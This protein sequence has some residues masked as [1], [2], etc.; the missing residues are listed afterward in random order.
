M[1]KSLISMAVASVVALPMA[2]TA[3]DDDKDPWFEGTEVYGSLRPQIVIQDGATIN[4]GTSRWG[5]KGDHD[6]G[7]GLSAIYRMEYRVDSSGQ[8]DSQVG[9]LGYA[10]L[11]GG[12]GTVALGEQW[13]PYYN[14]VAAPSDLFPSAGIVF[15]P[16]P[17]RKG[18]ALTYALPGGAAISGA[19]ML[20]MGDNSSQ[21]GVTVTGVNGNTVTGPCSNC[22]TIED[23]DDVDEVDVGL[24][25]AAGPVTIGLGVRDVEGAD[26]EL[27]G[28]S[29]AGSFGDAGVILLVEDDGDNTPWAITGTYGGFALQYADNDADDDAITLGYTHKLGPKAKLQFAIEDQDSADDTKGVARVRVD[30]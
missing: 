19:I 24:S 26:D 14:V 8:N 3:M 5:V 27:V 20:V 30:F 1:K 16:T 28:L 9:R 22:P 7:N 18:N 4:D 10:G 21:P 2:A 11:S 23:D 25:V 17:F 15:S 6:L 29:L 13:T 12:F